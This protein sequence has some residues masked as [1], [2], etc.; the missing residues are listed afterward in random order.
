MPIQTPDKAVVPLSS[1]WTHGKVLSLVRTLIGELDSENLQNWTLRTFIN[2]GISEIAEMLRLANEPFYNVM[3]TGVL[4][5]GQVSNLDWIDLGTPVANATPTA[6]TGQRP[7][8]TP[9]NVTASSFIPLNMLATIERLTSIRTAAQS[10][11]TDQILVGNCKKANIA[12]LISLAGDHNESYRQSILWCW[13]ADRLMLYHGAEVDTTTTGALTT[14]RYYKRPGAYVLWGTR[15]P[16]L[17]DMESPDFSDSGYNQL[18]DIPDRHVRLLTLMVQK[19]ALE[20]MRKQLDQA[21]TQELSLLTQSIT[22]NIIQ[23]PQVETVRNEFDKSN[24]GL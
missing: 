4:E 1:H 18:V 9:P 3:W 7:F 2:A 14:G 5:A 23:Q 24:T 11:V 19:Q 22:Q 8:H 21:S 10:A 20:S 12:D 16:L 6:S 15:L 17:D 13:H